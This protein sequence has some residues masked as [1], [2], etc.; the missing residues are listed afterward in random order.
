MLRHGQGA[1]LLAGEQAREETLFLLGI[2]V[3]R[4]LVDAELRV[5]CVGESDT[6]GGPTDLL[7]DYTMGLIS[8]AETTVL[9]VGRD[10]EESAR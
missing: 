9:F 8:H 1:D 2:S 7:H 6:P 3:Q 4:K 5:G 10:A